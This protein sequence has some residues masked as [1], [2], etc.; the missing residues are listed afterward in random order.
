[1][2]RYHK[3]HRVLL[4][5]I[6]VKPTDT[7]EYFLVQNQYWPVD[8]NGHVFFVEYHPI[9]ASTKR[10]AYFYVERI[11]LPLKVKYTDDY[12]RIYTL[13]RLEKAWIK[14]YIG[15]SKSKGV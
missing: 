14:N 7:K 8:E 6:S 15:Y 5:E 9:Y 12:K 2:G 10:A 13:V 1:M 4:K 3:Y 11:G